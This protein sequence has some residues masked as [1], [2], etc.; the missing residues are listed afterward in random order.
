VTTSA[1]RGGTHRL[2][3]A[4]EIVTPTRYR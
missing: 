4:Q 1:R 3:T 2:K